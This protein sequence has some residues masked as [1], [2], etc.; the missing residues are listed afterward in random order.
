VQAY[1]DFLVS[2]LI[3]NWTFFGWLTL[4]TETSIG[5]LLVAILVSAP[6]LAVCR[7]GAAAHRVIGRWE[8]VITGRELVKSHHVI[9]VPGRTHSTEQQLS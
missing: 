3:P 9:D 4:M 7:G 2:V 1:K 8:G 6:A 5:V